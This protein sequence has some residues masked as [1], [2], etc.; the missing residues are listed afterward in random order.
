M[1]TKQLCFTMWFWW[2]GF[3]PF[4]ILMGGG[5]TLPNT[6]FALCEHDA[7]NDVMRT[8]K[9][10]YLSILLYCTIPCCNQGRGGCRATFTQHVSGPVLQIRIFPSSGSR[11]FCY[12]PEFECL[13]SRFWH[14]LRIC[15]LIISTPKYAFLMHEMNF[16]QKTF[17]PNLIP[18]MPHE[19]T[20]INLKVGP[21]RLALKFP[22]N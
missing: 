5:G 11:W 2:L 15:T 12:D 3:L 20:R 18:S 9:S 6:P 14:S 1:I 17:Y 21:I 19:E 8:K 22:L 4:F 16:P 13:A 7:V 10:V